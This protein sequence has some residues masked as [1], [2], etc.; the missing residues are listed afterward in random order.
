M[1]SSSEELEHLAARLQSD[2]SLLRFSESEDEPTASGPNETFSEQE[3]DVNILTNNLWSVA[4]LGFPRVKVGLRTRL[5]RSSGQ[6]VARLQK[7]TRG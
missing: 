4:G 1:G 6:L 7:E 5:L 2:L 3:D